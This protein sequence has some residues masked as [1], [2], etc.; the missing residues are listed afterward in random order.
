MIKQIPGWLNVIVIWVAYIILAGS[1]LWAWD[2]AEAWLGRDV[3]RVL[4]LY[5]A[6][7]MAK[8]GMKQGGGLV[9]W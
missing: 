2:L 1:L 9:F 3:V 5:G 8:W 7:Y 4:I 6:M